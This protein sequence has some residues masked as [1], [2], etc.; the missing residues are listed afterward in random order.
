[1]IKDDFLAHIV[2]G[3][4][5][6]DLENI[7]KV[8]TVIPG[9]GNANFPLALLAIIYMDYL[10][11]FLLGSEGDLEKNIKEY[12]TCFQNP[13]DYPPELLNDLFRNGLAH[14]YFARGGISRSGMRPPMVYAPGVGV[15]LD[16]DSLLNDFIASL[17][18]FKIKLT[19]E[20]FQK[21]FQEAKG[22]LEARYSKHKFIIDNLPKPSI[23]VQVA[24]NTSIASGASLGTAIYSKNL[25]NPDLR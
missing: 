4:I 1:M 18:N 15:I 17:E 12:L 3:W 7:S 23:P 19:E 24:Q 20:N 13:A 22:I 16:A 11:S 6:K 2:F 5:K 9:D 21:R 25:D 14:D 8:R 10:G